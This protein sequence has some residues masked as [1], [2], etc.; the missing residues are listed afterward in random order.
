ML[1][2]RFVK[3]LIIGSLLLMP[4]AF[5][6]KDVLPPPAGLHQELN[7]A[8]K[9]VAVQV[10]LIDTTVNGVKY[11]IQPRYAYDLYGLVVSLHDSDSWYDYVH[12]EWNDYLNVVDLCVVWGENI[13]RDAYKRVNYSQTQTECFWSTLSSEAARA[14]DGSAMSNNHLI[15]DN[16]KMARRLRQVRIGDEVHFRGYLANYTIYKNGA[17][18]GRRVTSV[19]RT[20]TGNGACEVVYIQEFEILRATNRV[21][22]TIGKIA[23]WVFGLSVLAWFALPL[24]YHSND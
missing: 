10:G 24:K 13:R 17:P 5:L 16:P 2:H 1:L 3:A 22:R 6:R 23:V 15:T 19:T 14:F 9:Q 12:K 21:W 4:V 11:S 20:D 18:T 7:E 8:P